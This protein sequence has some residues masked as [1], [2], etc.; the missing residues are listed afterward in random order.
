MLQVPGGD[1]AEPV[2]EQLAVHPGGVLKA[3]ALGVVVAQ[4]DPRFGLD[5]LGDPARGEE[6]V[7]SDGPAKEHV[8]IGIQEV[9]GE[10]LDVVQLALHSLRIVG[11]QNRGVGEKLFAAH[12]RHTRVVR[13]PCGRGGVG[14]DEDPADPRRKHVDRTQ[15]VLELIDLAEAGLVI[16]PFAHHDA[17][18]AGAPGR[19]VLGGAAVHPREHQ[20]DVE[21]DVAGMVRK[22]VLDGGPGV[23]VAFHRA[24]HR[25]LGQHRAARQGVLDRQDQLVALEAPQLQL[26]AGGS[27]E[28]KTAL[29][30]HPGPVQPEDPGLAVRRELT[31]GHQHGGLL[32]GV[33]A[34][35]VERFVPARLHQGVAEFLAVFPVDGDHRTVVVAADQ[36]IVEAGVGQDG[37]QEHQVFDHGL[38]RGAVLVDQRIAATVTDDIGTGPESGH[39][40]RRG[41][42]GV[43]VLGR[44]AAIVNLVLDRCFGDVRSPVS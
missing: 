16:V 36:Q 41:D 30:L 33:H 39:G 15:G 43:G 2:P 4:A 10:S 29:R 34:H 8:V 42:L 32:L 31:V 40:G 37:T 28:F 17:G 9:L 21:A 6:H 11:R 35:G 27:A 12:D 19:D 38:V 14:G 22:H 44:L 25:I 5:E 13:Q 3:A 23:A 20:V 18:H 7:R 24:A 1:A 26:H